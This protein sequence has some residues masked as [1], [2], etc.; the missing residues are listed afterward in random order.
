MPEVSDWEDWHIDP[1][2]DVLSRRTMEDVMGQP[3]ARVNLKG[4]GSISVA[5]LLSKEIVPNP[6]AAHLFFH[7]RDRRPFL[8]RQILVKDAY[9]GMYE[10]HRGLVQRI[11]W[12][13]FGRQGR[14]RTNDF[15]FPDP[16]G[17]ASTMRGWHDV[18]RDKAPRLRD[19][20]EAQRESS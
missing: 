10:V 17:F 6:L 4:R 15:H 11:F 9:F 13:G 5:E 8:S 20:L 14:F 3:W 7:S 19:Y 12:S 16:R 1:E 18:E 2:E